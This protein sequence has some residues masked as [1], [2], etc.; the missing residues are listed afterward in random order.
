MKK[1]EEVA[2]IEIVMLVVP[3]LAVAVVLLVKRY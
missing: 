1:K 2:E 3:P